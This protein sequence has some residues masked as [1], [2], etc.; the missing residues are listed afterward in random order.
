MYFNVRYQDTSHLTVTQQNKLLPGDF[1]GMWGDHTE[2][3][4]IHQGLPIFQ[5]VTKKTQKRKEN[6]NTFQV[7]HSLPVMSLQRATIY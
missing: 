3:W 6:Q 7:R 5:E 2:Q 1:P 4:S